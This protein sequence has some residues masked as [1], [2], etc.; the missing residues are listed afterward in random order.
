[1]DAVP[2]AVVASDR[3]HLILSALFISSNQMLDLLVLVDSGAQGNFIN[4]ALVAHHALATTP[5]TPSIQARTVNGL[6]LPRIDTVVAANLTFHEHTEDINL[7]VTDIGNFD[8]ILGLPWL[9]QH[10]P[11]IDWKSQVLRF[12]R[13]NC[14]SFPAT[15][16]FGLQP[17]DAEP[18]YPH[19]SRSLPR[20][21]LTNPPDSLDITVSAMPLTA[22]R[23]SLVDAPEFWDG[24]ADT[25]YIGLIHV[26]PLTVGAVESLPSDESGGI[27]PTAHIFNPEVV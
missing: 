14:S 3:E 11:E 22:E 27:N 10:N 12:S 25:Q 18:K 2:L 5:R 17:L 21:C 16:N 24:A 19:T 23:I 6:P 8:A 20:P 26:S 15:M 13:C 4:A 9:Q 7:D 1:M